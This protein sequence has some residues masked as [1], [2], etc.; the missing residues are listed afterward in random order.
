MGADGEIPHAD[1]IAQ[2]L[3]DFLAK[4][5]DQDAAGELPSDI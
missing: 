5:L 4:R 1:Q 3:Q 2:E